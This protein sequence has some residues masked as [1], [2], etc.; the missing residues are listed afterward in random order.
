MKPQAPLSECFAK[1]EWTETEIKNLKIKIDSLF[2]VAPKLNIFAPVKFPGDKPRRP[3]MP[4]PTGLQKSVKHI[5]VN[6]V[7][8]WRYAIPDI[9]TSLNV[10]TGT[11]LH[12]LRTPLDQ[13]LSTI[14]A[15]THGTVT[16]IGFPF[17]NDQDRFEAALAGQKKLTDDAR[18]MISALKPYKTGN[19]L[20]FALHALNNPDKHHPGLIPIAMQ[21]VTGMTGVT[22]YNKGMVLSIGPRTGRHLVV[23]ANNNF[24]Q[25]KHAKRP[26]LIGVTQESPRIALGVDAVPTSNAYVERLYDQIRSKPRED[27]ADWIAKAVPPSDSPQDDMEIATCIPGTEFEIEMHPSFNIAFSDIAGFEREPI[28]A[29][30]HQMR[31]LVERILLTF[32]GRFFPNGNYTP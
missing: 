10:M 22:I 24:V 13:M 23:D 12:S 32:K 20:L 11:I 17:G 4:Y 2:K 21:S 25:P 16:G 1:I 26:A 28:V 27:L 3:P 19:A 6:G 8:V 15:Q 29:V 5:D 30:L 7:E 18:A 14:T 9:P 31:E